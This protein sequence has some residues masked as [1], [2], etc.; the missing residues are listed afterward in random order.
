[1][2]GTGA[3]AERGQTDTVTTDEA[4]TVR[5]P[6]EVIVPTL[7]ITDI[8]TLREDRTATL[9]ATPSG[10]V[11]DEISYPW[12]IQ[13]GSGSLNQ[14]TGSRVV[15]TPADVAVDTPVTIRCVATAR[16]TGTRAGVGETG[17]VQVEDV[18]LSLIHI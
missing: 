3:T 15:Y 16:G 12:S 14:S 11:Y 7:A 9:I 8:A 5:V 2:R 18:L 4:F 17:T 10:G 1:M 6:G 13:A